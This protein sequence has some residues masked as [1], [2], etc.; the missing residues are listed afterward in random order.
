MPVH[1]DIMTEYRNIRQANERKRRERREKVSRELPRVI[2]IER[3]LSLLGIEL[4]RIIVSP[5]GG[6]SPE[7]KA[8]DLRGEMNALRDERAALF[9]ESG[10]AA[11]YLSPI[12]TCKLC[13]DSGFAGGQK[14]SCYK[15]KLV[16]R[17]SE[18]SGLSAQSRGDDF[19]KMDLRWYSDE[20]DRT[21]G[22]SPR[23]KMGLVKD[24]C[25]KYA[26]NFGPNSGSL[27]IYGNTG[28]G[29]T[30]LCNCV[31]NELI[32]KGF[33]VLYFTASQMFKIIEDN[34]FNRSDENSEVLSLMYSGDLLIIDDLGTEFSTAV[35]EADFFNIIN[36]RMINRKP[37]IISTNRDPLD[38]NKYYSERIASRIV[39]NYTPLSVFGDDVRWKMKY[40]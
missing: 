1:A 19:D 28:I 38:L 17:L 35:T 9:A 23:A 25:R 8:A 3:D 26:A 22:V 30:L 34:R 20:T 18:L 29:K 12:Y 40:S 5:P 21:Y 32:R 31:A 10:L 11:D 39:G 16:A 37:V 36:I 27:Y 15:N 33:V 4:S 24:L 6:V 13:R 14:C 7:Q 2:R